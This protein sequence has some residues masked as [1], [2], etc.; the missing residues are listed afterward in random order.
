MRFTLEINMDND[1]F[2]GDYRPELRRIIQESVLRRLHNWSPASLE[3][4]P[5]PLKDVNGNTC[6]K[7]LFVPDVQS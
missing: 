4:D 7:M 3:S 6:G 2:A 1:A 5:V